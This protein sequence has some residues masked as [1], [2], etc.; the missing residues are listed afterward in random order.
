MA[1]DGSGVV[2][3]QIALDAEAVKAVVSGGQTIDQA[4]RLTDLAKSGWKVGTWEQPKD[5]SATLQLTHSFRNVSE[6]AGILRG[7]S[8]AD[9]PFRDLHAVRERGLLSTRYGLVGRADL[10]HVKTGVSTDPALVKSLTALGVNVSTLDQQLLA[11]VTSSFSL[12]IVARLPGHSP[13]TITARPGKVTQIDATASVRNT[14]RV[15]LLI[16]AAGL[17]LLSA[18]LWI[19]GGRRRRRRRR[20][21]P[22]QSARS[23]RPIP[24]SGR[25][26]PRRPHRR[27]PPPSPGQVVRPAPGGPTRGRGGSVRRHR[28]DAHPGRSSP[29]AARLHRAG[30]RA[31]PANRHQL[32]AVRKT[33]ARDQ[34]RRRSRGGLP[35]RTTLLRDASC[36]DAGKGTHPR[37]RRSDPE[38]EPA[39]S[40]TWRADSTRKVRWLT[41][42]E[43]GSRTAQSRSQQP[44]PSR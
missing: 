39:R 19:R 4:V 29:V 13:T 2:T 16:A 15:V 11:Q 1:E 40:M 35:Q 34:G 23:T 32:R 30:L 43:G 8:G 38:D 17:A 26:P 6:V 37:G 22:P 27:P 36:A 25:P 9:G 14:R 44:S 42:A 5:G 3:V 41:P 20:G 10:R 21:G 24:S 33:G 12:K 31:H 18:A 7:V 28:A